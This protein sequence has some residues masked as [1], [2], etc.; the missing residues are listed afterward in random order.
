ML[1]IDLN[2]LAG[3]F[4]ATPW[5]RHV[6]EGE[7][8]W[9]PSPWRLLRALVSSWKRTAPHLSEDE[10]ASVIS[11]L[12]HPPAFHL[13]PAVAGH[14]RHYMPQSGTS[15]LLVH[16]PHIKMNREGAGEFKPLSFLWPDTQLS[17]QEEEVLDSLLVGVGYFGRAE[18]WCELSRNPQPAE[19]NA[20]LSY[21]STE[22]KGVTVS[23]LCPDPEVN[24]E[25]LMVETSELQKK[26]YNRPPG[27]R[28]L[29]YQREAG[30]LSPTKRNRRKSEPL[31]HV[32]VYLIQA[33]V[34]PKVSELL[35]ISEWAR[36]GF[37]AAYG[38]QNNKDVSP[39]FTGKQD[40]QA[41]TDC[42]RHA[43]FIPGNGNWMT[44]NKDHHQ[45]LDRLYVYSPEGFGSRELKVIKSIR[46]FP[47]LR[48]RS[49]DPA[50]ESERFR[51]IPLA[52]VDE[53]ECSFLFGRGR[54]W[55]SWS[56][57]L[58]TRHPKKN[59]RDSDTEQIR[60]ECRLRGLP[61][62]ESIEW[63]D[64]PSKW[65]QFKTRRWKD[66]RRNDR[67]NSVP[68]VPPR[69]FRIIFTAPVT[70]PLALGRDCHFGMGLFLPEG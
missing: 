5:G 3:R 6:N 22:S 12:A 23:L 61:E 66:L 49:M 46:S 69:G 42:H 36:M 14:T 29:S 60:R 38:N 32:A 65:S 58:C 15:K 54:V 67:R 17:A 24:L 62:I 55:T 30:G 10:V 7:P 37:N 9:P 56:P 35:R 48:R 57:Y 13:P 25:Q 4:H 27:S 8:E 31:R 68:L 40:G 16:D 33:R 63:L 45:R 2:F 52:L 53:R 19:P 70:G 50:G 64:D 43:F 34:L 44:P 1:R 18:S 11:K 21:V 20:R 41:R 26:G 39:S 28:F 51:L 47:D 59:G